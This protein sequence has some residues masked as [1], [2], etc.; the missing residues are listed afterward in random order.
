VTS[1]IHI[2]VYTFIHAHT[3]IYVHIPAHTYGVQFFFVWLQFFSSWKTVEDP[4]HSRW[5][6][7]R[8]ASTRT[9]LQI[10]T[11]TFTYIHNT[12]CMCI[13]ANICK[14]MYTY[15]HTCSYM[16]ISAHTCTVAAHTCNSS[17]TPQP[18]TW[19]GHIP[20]P[21]TN[22][23]FETDQRTVLI[24]VSVTDKLW[25]FVASFYS[26]PTIWLHIENWS[27]GSS[28]AHQNTENDHP[29]SAHADAPCTMRVKGRL[30]Q[31]WVCLDVPGRFYSR[32]K[33]EQNT[34]LLEGATFDSPLSHK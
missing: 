7:I 20:G 30:G 26:F 14:Y 8:H 18:R 6:D 13:P 27:R 2:H 34:K 15:A 12:K 1:Y 24:T 4:R 25:S 28:L 11:N 32:G 31:V 3:C 19:N 17:N 22:D 29:I 16:H 5:T 10:P 21:A 23:L 9:Y 33:K